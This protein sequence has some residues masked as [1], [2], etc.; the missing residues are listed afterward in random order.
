MLFI[1]VWP[2]SILTF[3]CIL[4]IQGKEVPR[5]LSADPAHIQLLRKPGG[6]ETDSNQTH[7]RM[8]RSGGWPD[9][10]A[11]PESLT[12]DSTDVQEDMVGGSPNLIIPPAFSEPS[13]IGAELRCMH[14]GL[15]VRK[16]VPEEMTKQKDWDRRWHPI[17]KVICYF[18]CL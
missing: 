12:N 5:D 4:H 11:Q 7:F 10:L 18:E 17:W 2:A 1:I 16:K 3:H 9:G 6:I 8:T 14:S 15:R 13:W